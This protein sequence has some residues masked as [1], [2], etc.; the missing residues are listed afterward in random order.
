MKFR[1]DAPLVANN[2]KYFVTTRNEQRWIFQQRIV[3][4]E[5][6]A[7][8]CRQRR[9]ILKSRVERFAKPWE[10]VQPKHPSLKATNACG[11]K[12]AIC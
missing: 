2:D 10:T 3:A 4:I 5:I 9:R 7:T 12:T 1:F 6:S 8:F 11:T